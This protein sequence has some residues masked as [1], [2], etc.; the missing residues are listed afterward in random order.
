MTKAIGIDLGTTYTVVAVIENGKPKIIP[1]TEGQPLTPSVVAFTDEGR[2]LVGQIARR[3]AA[4]N[5]ER[6]VYSI[7]RRMGSNNKVRIGE[8]E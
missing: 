2:P 5:P 1:N 8:R 3:Q 4:V 7:K 6:T